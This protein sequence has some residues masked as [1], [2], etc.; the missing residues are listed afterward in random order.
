MNLIG[1]YVYEK[2]SIGGLAS[3]TSKPFRHLNLGLLLPT[4]IKTDRW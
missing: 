1:R 2:L 3:E 4:H